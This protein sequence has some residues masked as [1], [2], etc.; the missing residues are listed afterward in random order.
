M[1]VLCMPWDSLLVRERHTRDPCLQTSTA[2]DEETS[3][4]NPD[5][6]TR[7]ALTSLTSQLVVQPVMTTSGRPRWLGERGESETKQPFIP[8]PSEI[9]S[10][11]LSSECRNENG[12]HTLYFLSGNAVFVPPKHFS[13]TLESYTGVCQPFAKLGWT[14]KFPGDFQGRQVQ[15]QMEKQGCKDWR[16]NVMSRGKLLCFLVSFLSCHL[17]VLT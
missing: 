12:K 1:D 6:G 9:L 8:C 16:A 13:G 7:H 2:A 10:Q 17:Y 5:S 14:S 11:S 15:V 3:A 4:A